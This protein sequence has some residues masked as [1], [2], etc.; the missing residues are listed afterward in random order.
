MSEFEQ[1]SDVI[2]LI[3]GKTCFICEEP[4]DQIDNKL[5]SLTSEI[6]NNCTKAIEIRSKQPQRSR[7]SLDCSSIC[8]PSNLYEKGYHQNCYKRLINISGKR[9][10]S[11]AENENTTKQKSFDKMR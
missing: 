5:K 6:L 10:I 9:K 1:G 2:E 3:N 4:G 8:L 7:E 11:E